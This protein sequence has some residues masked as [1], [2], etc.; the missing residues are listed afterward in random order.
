MLA[1]GIYSLCGG[2]TRTAVFVTFTVIVW[3][4]VA[5]SAFIDTLN[6]SD[7]VKAELHQLSPATYTGM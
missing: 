3:M 5:I 2:S 7:A 1:N 6:V 4:S